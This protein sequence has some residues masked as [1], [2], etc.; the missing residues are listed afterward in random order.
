MSTQDREDVSNIRVVLVA[1]KEDMALGLID[2]LSTVPHRHPTIPS[3][4]I[5]AETEMI[6]ATLVPIFHPSSKM[7]RKKASRKMIHPVLVFLL[8]DSRP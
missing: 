3:S 7:S 5:G 1:A 6:R 8:I 4:F 2:T